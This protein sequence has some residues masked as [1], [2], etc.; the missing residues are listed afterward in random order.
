M[1]NKK[2]ANCMEN[3]NKTTSNSNERWSTY[4]A[5]VQSYRS[6]MI[7]SQ[8]FLLAVGA[9]LLGKNA[10]LLGIC[11]AVALFQLW[12]IWYRV[13][14]TRTIIVDYHKFNLSN[15]FSECGNKL[16]SNDCYLTEE[17]YLKNTSIR[18]KVNM[19]LAED[20]NKPKLKHNLRL[21]RIKIDLILPITFTIIWICLFVVDVFSFLQAR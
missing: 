19:Q 13:I 21:T 9:V 6:N 12:Y 2:G 4:E 1:Q 7:A 8:S 10:F 3:K 5:N 15:R 11:V 14:R 16:E 20:E 18:R 17:T